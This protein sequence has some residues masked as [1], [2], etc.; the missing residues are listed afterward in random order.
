MD[1]KKTRLSR[2]KSI[3]IGSVCGVTVAAAL[4]VIVISA[5][6]IIGRQ[7]DVASY[8][9]GYDKVFTTGAGDVDVIFGHPDCEAK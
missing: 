5:A 1:E 8:C 2:T 4:G 6:E 3:V 9:D 7:D